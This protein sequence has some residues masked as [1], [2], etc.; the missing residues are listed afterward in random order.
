MRK[1]LLLIGIALA[2][3]LV[4]AAGEGKQTAK[5][6]KKQGRITL[7]AGAEKLDSLTHRHRSSDGKIWF[8]RQTPFGLVRY[9]ETES[10]GPAPTPG[11]A[12]GDAEPELKAFD[13][14]EEVRFEKKGPFG[15]STWVRKK[16][17][18]TD[19]EHQAWERAR[20]PRESAASQ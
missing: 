7:P 4:W 6:P 9:E 13:A 12:G 19:E 20:Q 11:K 2:M 14:G 1:R 8:Y 16:G 5:P 18:L 10:G 17:E 15:K 3:P